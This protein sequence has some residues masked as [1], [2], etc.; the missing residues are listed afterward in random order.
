MAI[1]YPLSFPDY[2]GIT[3]ITL[4]QVSAAKLTES[5]FTFKQQSIVHTGQ[6]W[7]ADVSLPPMK[8]EDAKK[9]IAW[10][11]SLR[12]TRGTFL[13]GDPTG[14]TAAGS[15]PTLLPTLILDFV[16][17]AY[18]TI[19]DGVYAY[20]N[21]SNQTGGSLNISTSAIST[22]GFLLAGDYIQL[23]SGSTTS[24]HLVLQDV[25]T[26]SAGD[27]TLE[28]WPDVRTAPVDEATVT[29]T[30][31]QGL[32]RLSTNQFM[33]DINSASTFGIMFTAVEAVQ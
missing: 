25:D 5:P 7:E 27:A 16:N 12:G 26:D 24:L 8:A 9:W 15:L 22:T 21:G 29:V 10:L 13:M 18:N 3:H 32:W 31:P 30:N 2:T 1:S 23:G 28:L 11:S 6:R 14:A 4:R 33:W 17:G 19:T 20:V